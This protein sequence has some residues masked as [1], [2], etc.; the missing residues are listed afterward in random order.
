MDVIN[1]FMDTYLLLFESFKC[2]AARSFS[3]CLPKQ[4]S[5]TYDVLGI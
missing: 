5:V 4:M 1:I 3:S 2:V